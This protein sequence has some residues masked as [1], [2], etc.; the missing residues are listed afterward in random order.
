LPCSCNRRQHRLAPVFQFAEVLQLLL[1]VADLHLVQIAG[2]L[3]AVAR[4]EG[5]GGAPVEQFDDRQHPLQ[6]D[7]QQLGDMNE[8]GGGECLQFSHDPVELS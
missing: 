4:N 6:R 5:H 8:Y 1:D 7:V 2:G 3:L